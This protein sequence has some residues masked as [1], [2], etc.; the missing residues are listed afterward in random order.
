[1]GGHVQGPPLTQLL[2]LGTRWGEGNPGPRLL[3]SQPL[4]GGPGAGQLP[5]CSE[6]TPPPRFC[7][8]DG[9]YR[10]TTPEFR[11]ASSVEQLNTIEVGAQVAEG[12][13]YAA[14]GPQSC[15]GERAGLK[16]VEAGLGAHSLTHVPTGLGP[17]PL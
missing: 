17:R 15:Q 3:P 13:G 11:V 6:D 16:G 1:M 10:Q 2:S 5:L 12:G 7:V 4:S 9:L 14:G 8:A